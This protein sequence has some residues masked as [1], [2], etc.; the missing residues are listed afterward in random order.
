MSA[1]PCRIAFDMGS[2][3][4]RA[5]TSETPKTTKQ[6]FDAI[7]PLWDGKGVAA[8]APATI[9]PTPA[10][11]YRAGHEGTW[12]CWRNEKDLHLKREGLMGKSRW[13]DRLRQEL[14]A[15]DDVDSVSATYSAT[16]PRQTPSDS[17]DSSEVRRVQSAAAVFPGS[18]HDPSRCLQAAPK[19]CHG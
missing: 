14:E 6:D 9:S 16:C 19:A 5:G 11:T 10:I 15:D 13:S 17:A 7:G 3:G 12:F 2:S 8:I 4:I 1:A 18:R